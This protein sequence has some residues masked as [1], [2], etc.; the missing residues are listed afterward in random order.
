MIFTAWR[1]CAH[2]VVWSNAA[3]AFLHSRRDERDE[4]CPRVL[5]AQARAHQQGDD[6]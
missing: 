5:V 4:L 6:L 1:R 3:G 2:L